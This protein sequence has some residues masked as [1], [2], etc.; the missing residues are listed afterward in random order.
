MRPSHESF[1]ESLGRLLGQSRIPSEAQMEMGMKR[2][3]GQLQSSHVDVH[4]HV[5]RE[6]LT[7]PKDYSRN[8]L[9]KM[10]L[11][12]S[13][14]AASVLFAVGALFLKAVIFPGNVYAIVETV[15]GSVYRM[16]DGMPRT[17]SVG[18]T[19]PIGI[20]VRTDEGAAAVLKLST[21]GRIEMRSNSELL[22]E[23]SQDGVRIRL[24]DGSVRVT[25][26]QPQS[27]NLYVQNREVMVPVTTY[28]VA[29][30]QQL[31]IEFEAADVH[32]STASSAGRR[33]GQMEGVTGNFRESWVD[34]VRG[35]RY[36]LHN[37][38]L[39]DLIT[40]AYDVDAG[41]IVGA[42]GWM[43]SD[44][45]RFDIVGK[46]PAGKTSMPAIRTMLQSLLTDRFKLIARRDTRSLPAWV[47][48]KGAG[49]PKLKV[50][51]M[52]G[53]SGCRIVDNNERVSCRSVTLDAFVAAIRSGT[54]TT[55][56]VLNSTGIEGLWDFDLNYTV[57]RGYFGVAA[58][59]PILDAIKRQLGL[60]LELSNV[61]QPVL[62]VESVNRL[63]TPNIPD[64]EN[65]LPPDPVQFEVASIRPCK[66]VNPLTRGGETGAQ[67][68]PSGQLTTGCMSLQRLI[69]TAWDRPG[70]IDGAPGWLNSTYFDI[71]A[72]APIPVMSVTDVK[73]RAMLRNLLTTRFQ[74]VS[75][76][77]DRVE[78]AY[79]LVADKP[80]LKKADPLSRT[81]CRE[82]DGAGFIA[83]IPS[84]VKCQNV[85]MAQFAESLGNVG[86][87]PGTRRPV[88]D[89]TGLD[90]AWDITLKYR[91]GLPRTAIEGV[92][93]D[94]T[95]DVT[96]V[97][98]LEQQLGLKLK[99]TKRPTQVFVLDHIEET[100]TE[101]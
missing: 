37:A 13:V 78:D 65:R 53:E 93:S 80:K 3:W 16:T 89:A 30:A 31:P 86:E 71:V 84:V 8:K 83:G 87:R 12:A 6:A 76:Y 77:E 35:G 100:P 73:F 57:T 40:T 45:D 50:A 18:E 11:L 101:N 69:A 21:G 14:A 36:E 88:V 70:R 63:P 54:L 60:E 48:S 97:E 56:P 90:G 15:Q 7:A 4:A 95:A 27:T 41:S 99:D 74:I 98:A 94:P 43:F 59:N 68:S 20:R 58:G 72:K 46:P 75:H 24:N 38:N 92:P 51:D 61:P 52:S 19:I 81:G 2:V 26:D 9:S 47:L 44:W 39:A 34:A 55:L 85:T 17:V 67:F 29:T 64:V 1:G 79:A 10:M 23:D 66:F 22:L 25:P 33:I 96:L 32:V 91:N 28:L 5:T 62:V 49:D 42:P 82:N